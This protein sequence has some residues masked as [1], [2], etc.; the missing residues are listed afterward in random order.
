MKW[1]FEVRM[2]KV[3]N[4]SFLLIASIDSIVTEELVENRS[5]PGDSKNSLTGKAFS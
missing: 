2:P 3:Q 1:L 5:D 4:I